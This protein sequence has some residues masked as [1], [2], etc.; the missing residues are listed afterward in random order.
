MGAGCAT[1]AARLPEA[2]M[3]AGAIASEGCWRLRKVQGG[4]VR[5][6]PAVFRRCVTSCGVVESAN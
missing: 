6:P 4:L 2:Q 1:A 5:G 3:E